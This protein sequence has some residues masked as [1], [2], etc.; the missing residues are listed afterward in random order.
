ML[1]YH[2]RGQRCR[3]R[4]SE[5]YGLIKPEKP[6]KE[7]AVEG[8]EVKVSEALV[9]GEEVKVP[10]VFFQQVCPAIRVRGKRLAC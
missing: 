9:E 7:E 2:M 5:E 3:F 4:P 10:E 1:D 8:E 6:E